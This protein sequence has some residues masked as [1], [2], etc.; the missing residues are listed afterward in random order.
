VPVLT[1]AWQM[2]LKGLGE[3]QA[4]PNPVAALEMLAIRLAHAAEL[5]TPGEILASLGGAPGGGGAAVRGAAPPP[6]APAATPPGGIQATGAPTGGVQTSAVQP[7]AVQA[8]GWGGAQAL[9]VEPNAHLEATPEPARPD[10]A[11]PGPQSF[12]D[13]VALCAAQREA[14]LAAHLRENVR[15]VRFEI[16]QIE[17]NP[18]AAAPRDL[19]NRLGELL[20][21]WTGRR[22]IVSLVREGGAATI[23][24][25][26]AA[27]RKQRS[28]AAAAH[29]LVR[30]VLDAFPGAT[31]EAV[32]GAIES[33][34]SEEAEPEPATPE[35][36]PESEGDSEA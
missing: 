34:A 31:I 26:E 33:P 20:S 22:W 6:G 10:L 2:L 12:A 15:L 16:G 27:Q 8:S 5:P 32:R 9:R 25:Q 35:D 4:A 7:S 28:D 13:I 17:L 21:K 29:P 14:M 1:R 24:E 3:A 36:G 19:A 11:P 23:E 30:A 18:A